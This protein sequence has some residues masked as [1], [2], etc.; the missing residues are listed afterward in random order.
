MSATLPRHWYKIPNM[1]HVPIELWEKYLPQMPQT[2]SFK[3]RC[4]GAKVT[5]VTII[6]LWKVVNEGEIW[7]QKTHKAV[8]LIMKLNHIIWS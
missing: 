8:R 3:W 5:E 4:S 2:I 1:T 6:P 7:K